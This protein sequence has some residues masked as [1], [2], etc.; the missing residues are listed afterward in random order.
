M[1]RLKAL[2][3]SLCISLALLMILAGTTPVRAEMSANDLIDE[4]DKGDAGMR[5][6]LEK[7][8]GGNANG[9]SWVNSYLSEF[10]GVNHLVYCPPD[11][12]ITDGPAFITMMR[13]T[14][15]TK[16]E[17]GSLP[18]GATVL[19]TYIDHYPCP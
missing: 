3:A 16:P 18:Y 14:L 17:Y 7:I 13:A 19:F 4:Y 9:V 15:A 5:H 11:D 8:V 2:C 12:A 10:R 1:K 6:L